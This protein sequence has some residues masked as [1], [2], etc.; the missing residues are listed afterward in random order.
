[1]AQGSFHFTR[2]A[3]RPIS[4]AFHP[5]ETEH[6]AG[7]SLYPLYHRWVPGGTGA[8]QHSLG[9]GLRFAPATTRPTVSETTKTYSGA[10]QLSSHD[11]RCSRSVAEAGSAPVAGESRLRSNPVERRALPWTRARISRGTRD[12]YTLLSSSACRPGPRDAVCRLL[13]CILPNLCAWCLEG[14]FC[15]RSPARRW[16]P[17]FC[18]VRV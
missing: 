10:E 17:F 6:Q 14:S 16:I 9:L 12:I 13:H 2:W 15:G 4:Q 7:E 3:Q 18:N 1:M 5:K 11:K 8:L